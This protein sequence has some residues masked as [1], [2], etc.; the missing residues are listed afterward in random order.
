M[1]SMLHCSVFLL[2]IFFMPLTII[3][4]HCAVSGGKSLPFW[5]GI[6][7]ELVVAPAITGSSPL[8][9]EVL[10]WGWRELTPLSTEDTCLI[11]PCR[12]QIS[13]YAASP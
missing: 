3:F 1:L 7:L 9:M 12:R 10:G 11:Q 4:P 5:W 2:V 6:L 8:G 13:G